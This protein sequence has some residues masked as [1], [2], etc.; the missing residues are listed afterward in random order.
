M[1]HIECHGDADGIQLTD[2]SLMPWS[3]LKPLLVN[4]NLASRMNLFLVM[5]CCY[6]GYFAAECRY[7]EPVPFAWIVFTGP[8][9]SLPA[10]ELGWRDTVRVD[11][12]TVTRIIVKSISIWV[13]LSYKT[14]PPPS[15]T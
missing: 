9:T 3:R 6:G 7:S 14:A 5:A 10:G 11:P 12:L 8:S 4:I 1:L 2:G 13:S 15:Q